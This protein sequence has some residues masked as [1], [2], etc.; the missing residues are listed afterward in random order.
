MT[1]H[2]LN[3]KFEINLFEMTNKLEQFYAVFCLLTES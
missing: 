3:F 2:N 1:M